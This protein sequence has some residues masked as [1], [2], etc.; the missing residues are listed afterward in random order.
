[1]T[2]GDS[3]I[4]SNSQ[5][6]LSDQVSANT[7]LILCGAAMGGTTTSAQREARRQDNVGESNRAERSANV[8]TDRDKHC[9]D[10]AG[11]LNLPSQPISGN[12]AV[13]SALYCADSRWRRTSSSRC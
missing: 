6:R 13:L 3:P 7:P 1:M 10:A 9:P 2:T 12:T 8:Q 5:H 11:M 4:G